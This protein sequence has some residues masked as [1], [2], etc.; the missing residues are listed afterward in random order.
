MVLAPVFDTTYTID[1][2]I[3]ENHV[4]LNEVK[5]LAGYPCAFV[6]MFRYAQHDNVPAVFLLEN[7]VILNEVKNLIV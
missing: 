5:N 1:Y 6:E 7:H 2:E 3:Y 4:I